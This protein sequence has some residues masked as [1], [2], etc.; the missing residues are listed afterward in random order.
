MQKI[1]GVRTWAVKKNYP[2]CFSSMKFSYRYCSNAP[3]NTGN[4][5]V[6]MAGDEISAKLSTGS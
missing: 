3:I 4:P 2:F 6:A 1:G 5:A